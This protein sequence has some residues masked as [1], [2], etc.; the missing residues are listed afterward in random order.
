[1]WKNACLNQNKHV[2][3]NLLI[4]VTFLPNFKTFYQTLAFFHNFWQI[5]TKTNLQ[6][7]VKQFDAKS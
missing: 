7:L 4:P 3:W 6:A 1:M 2:Y 5:I